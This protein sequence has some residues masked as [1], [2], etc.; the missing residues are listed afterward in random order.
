MA[1]KAA[2]Q[3]KLGAGLALTPQLRQA[4]RMLQLSGLELEQ[5]LREAMEANPLLELLEPGDPDPSDEE[6]AD[7]ADVDGIADRTDDRDGASAEIQDETDAQD[8]GVDLDG[9]DDDWSER[10]DTPGARPEGDDDREDAAVSDGLH[11]HLLWQLRMDLHSTRDLDIGAALV[12][13]LDDDGYLRE[14]LPSLAAAV[15]LV[16]PA[17]EDEIRVV[18]KQLQQLDPLGCGARDLSECLLLQLAALAC[19]TPGL[20][21][22]RRLAESHLDAV[23]KTRPERLAAD[24][25]VTAD[26]LDEALLLLRSLDPKPGARFSP[27]ATEYVQPDAM[28]SRHRGAWVVRLARGPRLA[29]NRHYERLI[30][31][32][33][34]E[35]DAYLRGQLQ[36]ARWLVKALE[37]RGDTLQRVADA[38]VRVQ[39]AFLDHGLEAMRPLTLREVAEQLELHESTISRA[40]SRKYLRTPR[41]TFEFKFFFSAGLATDHGGAAS[42]T[43]VQAMLKRLIDAE[44]QAKPLSDQALADALKAAGIAVARRTVAKYREGLGIPPSSERGGPG[45]R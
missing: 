34:R 11:E 1:I 2:L 26:A 10:H 37:N 32:C 45:P 24:L 9:F 18:L 19:D 27:V 12:D 15:A 25:E 39:S 40:T 14:S 41:G 21:L 28:V 17:G 7:D 3:A 6:E 33:S 5:E 13:A 36:E 35:D 29:V 8:E 4:I 42:A 44:P 16:P 31:H 22:A 30:G 20:A 43:A 23:A 38:I